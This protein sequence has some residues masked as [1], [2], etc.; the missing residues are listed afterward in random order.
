MLESYYPEDH[1]VLEFVDGVTRITV[2]VSVLNAYFTEVFILKV[3]NFTINHLF[4]FL[5]EVVLEVDLTF[6]LKELL[7]IGSCR[8]SL[9]KIFFS[10]CSQINIGEILKTCFLIKP[11]CI[12]SNLEL[13][14]CGHNR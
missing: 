13:P 10:Q 7:N 5:L 2:D 1:F 9:S 3:V 14:Q 11:R 6:A 4:I 12:L 8:I